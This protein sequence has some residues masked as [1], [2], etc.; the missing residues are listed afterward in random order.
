MDQAERVAKRNERGTS[1][2]DGL[3]VKD[4]KLR[5]ETKTMSK[6]ACPV[7]PRQALLWGSHLQHF[8]AHELRLE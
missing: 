7:D 1:A 5:L 8:M 3:F 4:K 2:K 6:D